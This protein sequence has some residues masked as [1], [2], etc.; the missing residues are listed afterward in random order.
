MEVLQRVNPLNQIPL[1]GPLFTPL[2]NV[3]SVA[4]VAVR[5]VTDPVFPSSIIDV[6][7]LVGKGNKLVGC[8]FKVPS[9]Q[10]SNDDLA[11]VVDTSDEWI[12]VCTGIRN[13]RVLAV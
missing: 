1:V 12:S 3:N 9:L 4:R 2:V 6:Y 8:G 7:V 5:A 10:V 11:K 13:R